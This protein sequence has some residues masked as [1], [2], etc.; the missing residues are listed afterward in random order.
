MKEMNDILA[1]LEDVQFSYRLDPALRIP[2]WTWR[3]GEHWA[4]VGGNGAGKTTLARL[5]RDEM[6][7]QRGT[8]RLAPNLAPDRDIVYVSFDM[9][10]ELIEYDNRFDDSDLRDD[11]FDVGTTVRQAILQGRAEDAAFQRLV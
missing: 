11:A 5:L 4:V 9:Q 6:R 10:R 3:P 2:S 7:P 8:I 1:T